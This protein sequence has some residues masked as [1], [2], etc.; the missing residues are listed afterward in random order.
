MNDGPAF[1]H[2]GIARG[3]V[4]EKRADVDLDLVTRSAGDRAL[5]ALGAGVRVEKRPEPGLGR[6]DPLELGP[7]PLEAIPLN[8]GQFFEGIARARHAVTAGRAEPADQPDG[9][10]EGFRRASHGF[11]SGS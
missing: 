9:E 8:R 4:G 1:Q 6:E 3:P 2:Q 7:A 5:V 10:R 11:P